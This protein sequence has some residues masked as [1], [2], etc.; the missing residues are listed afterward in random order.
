MKPVPRIS[1]RVPKI[2]DDIIVILTLPSTTDD[3]PDEWKE[4]FSFDVK[5]EK[6]TGNLIIS[7]IISGNAN[8]LATSLYA[9]SD[10][11]DLF[12]ELGIDPMNFDLEVKSMVTASKASK[13]KNKL[14]F[15]S[16]KFDESWRDLLC[17][18]E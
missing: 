17:F 2:T 8:A 3:V 14:K 15:K 11:E 13:P 7:K 1:E 9:L 5:R 12:R 4:E 16:K 18:L 6:R 10:L